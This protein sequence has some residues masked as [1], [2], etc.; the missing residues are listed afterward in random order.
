MCWAHKNK[1]VG[2]PFLEHA[3]AVADLAVALRVAATGRGDVIVT[4][5]NDLTADLPPETRARAKPLRLTVPVIHHGQRQMIGVEPDYAFSLTLPEVKRRAFFLAEIDRGTMPVERRDLKHSSILKKLLAYQAFW[6]A[7][8]HKMTFGWHN[9]RMLVVTT[10]AE[11]V[12]NM[13]EAA[14]GHGQIN[15]SPL[16][17]FTDTQTL[18][19][20]DDMLTARWRD[21]DGNFQVLLPKLELAGI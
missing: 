11:R 8:G 13:I 14:T 10:S 3:L 15:G 12:E 1:S 17:L 6:K 19:A 4:D 20:R 9:F 18:Y 2:R 21:S 16:I 7:K 5:G